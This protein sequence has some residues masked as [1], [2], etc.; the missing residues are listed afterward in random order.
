M[1]VLIPTS[2]VPSLSLSV[3]LV[4][5]EMAVLVWLVRDRDVVFGNCWK[6][7]AGILR[8]REEIVQEL[9][10]NAKLRIQWNLWNEI[11]ADEAYSCTEY[12][13]SSTYHF[14]LN[15]CPCPLFDRRR[16]SCHADQKIIGV[17][18]GSMP[19][20]TKSRVMT[21]HLRVRYTWLTFSGVL[22]AEVLLDVPLCHVMVEGLLDVVAVEFINS[23][24]LRAM[25]C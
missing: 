12:S 24:I 21:S 9:E 2:C 13:S 1:V 3:Q 22:H 18:C 4:G 15:F 16:W 11:W 7:R 5:D 25:L 14:Q 19:P 20:S 23:P 8:F 10:E 6:L 17:C